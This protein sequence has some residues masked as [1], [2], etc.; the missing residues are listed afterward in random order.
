[1]TSTPKRCVCCIDLARV[2]AHARE[3]EAALSAR[4]HEA[5]DALARVEVAVGLLRRLDD[6]GVIAI[7]GDV[8]TDVDD[9][10]RVRLD[11]AEAAL[12]TAGPEEPPDGR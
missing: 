2:E 11:P 10:A 1:M 5:V 7:A 9:I 12:F 8:I 3:L 6:A 4:S